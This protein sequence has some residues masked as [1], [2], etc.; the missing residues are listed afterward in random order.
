M[1]L[2]D[3]TIFSYRTES[4]SALEKTFKGEEEEVLP[5]SSQSNT[6]VLDYLIN[7]LHKLLIF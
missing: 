2:L 6:Y 4:L 7:V 5:I 3:E 1:T